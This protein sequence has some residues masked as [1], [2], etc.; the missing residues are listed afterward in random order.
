MTIIQEGNLEFTFGASWTVLKYDE[1]GSFYKSLMESK[2]K[3]T[4]AMDFLCLRDSTP[5]VMLEV[6]DFCRGVPKNEKFK[7]VP[8]T[9]AIKARDTLAGVIGGCHNASNTRECDFFKAS[10]TRMII[11]PQVVFFFEDLATPKRRPP[12]RILLKKNVL[13]KEL[14]EHLRWLTRNVAVVGLDDYSGLIPDLTVKRT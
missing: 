6:K 3:P 10:H 4:K 2:V 9:V 1:T 11:P 8:M 7:N 13:L 12:E 14:K 5:L